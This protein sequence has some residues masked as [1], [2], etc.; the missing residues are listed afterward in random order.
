MRPALRPFCFNAANSILPR[1]I[2]SIRLT[3]RSYVHVLWIAYAIY[4]TWLWATAG[5]WSTVADQRGVQVDPI[6]SVSR[7]R[8]ESHDTPRQICPSPGLEYYNTGN[9]VLNTWLLS[10]IQRQ[11]SRPPP[12]PPIPRGLRKSLS[13]LTIGLFASLFV[14]LWHCDSDSWFK[15]HPLG[16][17]RQLFLGSRFWLSEVITRQNVVVPLGH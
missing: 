13:F 5:P 9:V 4:K 7:I 16:H 8:S 17:W 1:I 11:Q 3:N 6:R 15:D 12:P 2:R 10:C 14:S